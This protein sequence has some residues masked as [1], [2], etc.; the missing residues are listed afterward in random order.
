MAP[1]PESATFGWVLGLAI[2][3]ALT[4]CIVV[5][6]IVRLGFPRGVEGSVKN[7]SPP[8]GRNGTQTTPETVYA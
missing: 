5:G 3:V 6:L 4:S 7:P 1:F 8:G 2:A